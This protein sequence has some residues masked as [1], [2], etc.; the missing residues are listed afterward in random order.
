MQVVAVGDGPGYWIGGEAHTF[1]YVGPDGEVILE[2]LRLAGNTLLW[3]R[4]GETFR[5][6]SG[7]GLTEAIEVAESIGG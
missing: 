5:L 7:L 2:T 3:E 6:E 4:D 1:G